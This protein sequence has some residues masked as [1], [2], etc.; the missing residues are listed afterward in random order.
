MPRTVDDYMVQRANGTAGSRARYTADSPC[1]A[2]CGSAT[3]LTIGCRHRDDQLNGHREPVDLSTPAA[4]GTYSGPLEVKVLPPGFS[5]LDRYAGS[6][7]PRVLP[8]QRWHSPEG[9]RHRVVK[10][11]GQ[12]VTLRGDRSNGRRTQVRMSTLRARWSFAPEVDR[13]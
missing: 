11:T 3:H 4:N 7:L 13:G 2:I 5:F 12:L 8:G 6:P 9:V 10:V 1:C